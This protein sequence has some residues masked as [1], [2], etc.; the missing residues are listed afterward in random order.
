MTRRVITWHGGGGQVRR[1]RDV[2]RA[3]PALRERDTQERDD[4]VRVR[5]LFPTSTATSGGTRAT[6]DGR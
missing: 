3:E 6:T 4:L 5:R 2:V 1:R